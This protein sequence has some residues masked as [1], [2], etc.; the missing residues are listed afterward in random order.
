MTRLN[1]ME[2]KKTFGK[3]LNRVAFGKERLLLERRGED[4]AAIVPLEDLRLLEELEDRFDLE[5]ARKALQE[6]GSVSLE[7]LKKEL[8]L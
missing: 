6:P 2:A 1:V 4:V 5:T 3:T 7:A 8:G